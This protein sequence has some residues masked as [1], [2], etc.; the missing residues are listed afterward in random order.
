MVGFSVGDYDVVSGEGL[1]GVSG[2]V[3][4]DSVIGIIF[5]VDLVYGVEKVR[6]VSRV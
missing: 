3:L 1:L 5:V 4:E 6:D 2:F